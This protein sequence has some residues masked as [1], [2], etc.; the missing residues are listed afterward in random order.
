TGSVADHRIRLRTGLVESFARA[1]AAELHKGGGDSAAMLDGVPAGFDLPESATKAVG[2]VARD[3]LKHRGR[4]VVIPGY[5]QPPAVH[6]PAHAMNQALGNVGQTVFYT[7]P[8]APR[9]ADSG[10]AR[11]AK[12]GLSALR[13]LTD[14][15]RAGEVELL[16]ILG[17]NPAFTAPADLGFADA[18]LELSRKKD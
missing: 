13:E 16:F 1:L 7:D 14:E 8:I 5:A 6:P 15:M 9:P 3:L 12:R 11:R 4:C 17:T 2:P 10:V 18:L